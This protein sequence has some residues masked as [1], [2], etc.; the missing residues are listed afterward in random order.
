MVKKG[1]IL[2]FSG[3]VGAGRSEIMKALC[4]IGGYRSGDLYFKGEK[5]HNRS[6]RDAIARKICYLTEDRKK[7]GIFLSMSVKKN[8][9]VAVLKELTKNGIIRD[10]KENKNA[11]EQIERMKVKT[12]DRYQL[13]G[14]LSGGN[15]QKAMIGK[16]MAVNPELIIM[17]EPTRGIDVGAKSEIHFMLRELCNQ[18]IGVILISSEMPE[19]IGLSDEVVVMHEGNYM[20]TVAGEDITESNLILLASGHKLA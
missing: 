17:D 12:Q 16:W 8:V 15:Q 9:S 20:G 1:R 2:G 7:N 6:Y 5:I 19:I 4:G 18:G 11:D 3:L 14:S 10:E 13:I